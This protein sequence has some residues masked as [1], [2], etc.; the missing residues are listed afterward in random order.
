MEMC[1]HCVLDPTHR[2]F[3]RNLCVIDC[4]LSNP[5]LDLTCTMREFG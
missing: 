5:L 2:D 3:L 1:P 4:I